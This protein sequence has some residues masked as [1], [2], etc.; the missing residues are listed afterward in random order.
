M[1]QPPEP[2]RYGIPTGH[3]KLNAMLER[4]WFVTIPDFEGPRAAFGAT[5]QA[6]HATIDG[7]R[8]V[9]SLA[10]HPEYPLPDSADKIRYA[11]WGY[12]GGSL[13]SEKAAELQ[14]QYA[15]EM[16]SGFVGAALGGLVSSAASVWEATNK[17]LYAGN[18]VLILL[19]T[20]NEYPEFDAHVRSRLKTEGPRNADGFLE[21]LKMNSLL[22]FQAYANQ[23]I[24]EYFVGGREAI[25]SSEV[26]R[27]IRHT[28][29]TL[30]FHG[31]PTMPLYIYK[32]VADEMT[33]IAD[34]DEHVAL[35]KR[36]GASILYERNTAGGHVPEI[37][38]GQE[39]AM[40]WLIDV[41]ENSH[42]QEG[43]TIRDVSVDEYKH[44]AL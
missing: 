28:E 31:C 1:F 17:T 10:G 40:K 12:S 7:I 32:A 36:F 15:P 35:Y 21:G 14:V 33:P 30:G 25:E 8:A 2:N 9:L 19:G 11:M 34:T 27:R 23:D 18:L 22:A 24:Y 13:A 39:R 29:W 43:V 26:Y 41:L 6:G 20:M 3:E 4:G 16:T 38:N 5:V 37:V 42:V 44:P